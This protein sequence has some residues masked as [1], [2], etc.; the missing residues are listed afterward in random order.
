MLC[1]VVPR[2]APNSP[3]A[4]VVTIRITDTNTRSTGGCC[5]PHGANPAYFPVNNPSP[6]SLFDGTKTLGKH[7]LPRENEH[8]CQYVVE[9]LL[10]AAS[11]SCQGEIGCNLLE[12][13][14][15]KPLPPRL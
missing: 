1:N 5:F 3:P 6:L 14:A 15:F 2:K 7:P 4:E 11:L 10:L 13:G 9:W 8:E 12:S